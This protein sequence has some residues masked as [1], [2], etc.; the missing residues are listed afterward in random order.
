[1]VASRSYDLLS[2]GRLAGSLAGP[3]A[4]GVVLV[5]GVPRRRHGLLAVAA[6]FAVLAVSRL[7]VLAEFRL[8]LAGSILLALLAARLLVAPA[9]DSPAPPAGPKSG[10]Q[11][12]PA[13]VA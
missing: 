13:E 1:M 3:L 10:A 12:Q 6:G 4:A 11:P 2:A 5:A 7:E 9:G 8:V